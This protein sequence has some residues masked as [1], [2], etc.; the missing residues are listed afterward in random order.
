MISNQ[1]ALGLLWLAG[2]ATEGGVSRSSK[3]KNGERKKIPGWLSIKG[4]NVC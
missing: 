2:R 1:G 3:K 4:G